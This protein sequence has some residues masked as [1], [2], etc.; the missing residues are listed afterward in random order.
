[1]SDSDLLEGNGDMLVV[2]AESNDDGVGLVLSSVFW[3]KRREEISFQ[4]F[5]RPSEMKARYDEIVGIVR[6]PVQMFHVI[7]VPHHRDFLEIRRGQP[8]RRCRGRHSRI[9]LCIEVYG[10]WLGR[11]WS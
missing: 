11:G 9:A 4:E 5:D 2:R 8:E 10:E 1:M 3:V 7:W 6:E